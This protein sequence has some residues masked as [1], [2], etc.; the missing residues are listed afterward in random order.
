MPRRGGFAFA[1]VR[2]F[3]DAVFPEGDAEFFDRANPRTADC[4]ACKPARQ[5]PSGIGSDANSNRLSWREASPS[6]LAVSL[7]RRLCVLRASNQFF[8]QFP[9]PRVG[10]LFPRI[11]GDAENARQHADDI[12]VENRRRLVE[13][14][15]ANRAG[16][17]TADARQREN[18]VKFSGNL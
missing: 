3:F 17:V 13:G 6:R 8:R 16:G 9:K 1:E 5:V 4:A 7:R 2:Q 14:D 18:V 11:F 10:F 12:A 15:A